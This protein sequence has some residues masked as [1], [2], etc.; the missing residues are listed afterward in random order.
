MEESGAEKRGV[1]KRLAVER[2]Y[3]GGSSASVGWRDLYAHS[4][5]GAAV[6]REETWQGWCTHRAIDN[7]GGSLVAPLWQWILSNVPLPRSVH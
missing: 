6:G 2:Y 3:F 4:K 7:G 1:E 5:R